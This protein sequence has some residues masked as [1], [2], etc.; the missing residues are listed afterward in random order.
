MAVSA[1]AAASRPKP[2]P[3][4]RC[5]Y[6]HYVFDDQ[7]ARFS[8]ALRSLQTM[9][10]FVDTEHCLAMVRGDL[11]VD[12]PYFHLSFDDGF[13]NVLENGAP[14]LRELG[15]PA[16]MLVPTD[17]IGTYWGPIEMLTWRGVAELRDLGIEIGSHSRT[18][19]R[20]ADLSR[21]E[22]IEE[23]RG[24][25][26]EVEERLG[27]ACRYFS[28]PFGGRSD[29]PADAPALLAESGYEGCFGATR[30]TVRV[31]VTDP[32]RIPRHHIPPEWPLSHIRFFAGGRWEVG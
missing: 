3:F 10:Q 22:V 32:Y 11:P 25:K 13:R 19:R 2:G 15:I 26:E 7:R 24:S 8:R 5:L 20:L 21:E 14:I 23:I 18:H 6:C 30:G 1:L 9:G 16:L 17:L 4:L 31:G 29:M 28:W 12:G 27:E